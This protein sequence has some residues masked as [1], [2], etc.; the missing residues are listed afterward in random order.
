MSHQVCIT[1]VMVWWSCFFL[2]YFTVYIRYCKFEIGEWASK[3]EAK[4][5]GTV[6]DTSYSSNCHMSFGTCRLKTTVLACVALRIGAPNSHEFL[7][8]Q[9]TVYLLFGVDWQ[10]GTTENY[11]YIYIICIYYVL[12]VYIYYII[13]TFIYI[14][15]YKYIHILYVILIFVYYI[16]THM[17]V[18]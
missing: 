2:V 17:C 3:V 9:A 6:I 10:L 7:V 4:E 11:I 16:Y 12:C 5:G 13:I 15:I 1:S 8:I 14:Y 18:C